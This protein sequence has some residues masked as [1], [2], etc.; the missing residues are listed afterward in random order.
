[1]QEFAMRLEGDEFQPG[2]STAFTAVSM[3]WA[4]AD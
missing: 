2:D 3:R 4:T 1:M